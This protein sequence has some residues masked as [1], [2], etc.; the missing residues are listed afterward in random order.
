MIKVPFGYKAWK[1]VRRLGRYFL[2]FVISMT[3]FFLVSASVISVNTTIFTEDLG[4]ILF[5]NVSG[6]PRPDIPWFNDKN[7]NVNNGSLWKLPN[8]SRNDNGTYRCEASNDC[9]M[10]SKTFDLI[11]QCKSVR[12]SEFGLTRRVLSTEV[13]GHSSS[14]FSMCLICTL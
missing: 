9:G 3:V 1:S 5:C 10:D 11:V 14:S 2:F 12:K 8:I 6:V 4:A 7:E 13:Q